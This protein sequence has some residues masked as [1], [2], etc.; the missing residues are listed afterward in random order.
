MIAGGQQDFE[1]LAFETKN[2][3]RKNDY[4]KQNP[5]EHLADNLKMSSECK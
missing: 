4:H 5:E 3:A 2:H 1:S